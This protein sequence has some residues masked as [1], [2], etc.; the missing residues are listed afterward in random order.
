MIEPKKFCL[1]MMLAVLLACGV[2]N[3]AAAPQVKDKAGEVK[4]VGDPAN[5][6]DFGRSVAIDGNLIAV[7]VGADGANGSVYLYRRAGQNYALEARLECP[8]DPIGAEFG[9]SVAIKGNTIFVGARFA[10]VADTDNDGDIDERD[11]DAGAVYIFKKH[12]REWQMEQKIFSPAPQPKSNFGRAL[13]IHGDTLIVTARKFDAV[14]END[15]TA[16]AYVFRNGLWTYQTE[17]IPDFEPADEA[18]FGQSVALQGDLLAIG[19]RNDNPNKAGSLYVFRQTSTGWN[20]IAKLSPPDGE[21]NDHYGFSV[22][23]SGNT[24]AA[25]A[26]R[27]DLVKGTKEETEEGA[28]YVYFVNGNNVELLTMLTASDAKAGDEFGQSITMA[29][30]VIA[31]GAPKPGIKGQNADQGTVYLFRRMG[32]RWTEINKVVASDGAAGDGFGYS[33]SAFGNRIV[34]GAHFADINGWPKAGAAYIL[35]LK[36]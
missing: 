2:G 26:R 19:A 9:R 3:A 24:I 29:G 32:D 11:A 17:I 20:Q 13:A 30:D 23:L 22:A 8:D 6:T 7:G 28:V 18:Y 16:Y 4:L 31:V 12:G 10:Q 36:P 27:A 35:P 21:K 1:L 25:G 14:S 5:E 33:L 15:G 34:T